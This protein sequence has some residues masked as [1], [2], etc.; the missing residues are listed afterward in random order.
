MAYGRYR[1]STMADLVPNRGVTGG[2]TYGGAQPAPQP[3]AEGP[4]HGY[5]Y[6]TLAPAQAAWDEE[7]RNLAPGQSMP[8]QRPGTEGPVTPRRNTP[9]S[10]YGPGGVTNPGYTAPTLPGVPPGGGGGGDPKLATPAYR[11]HAYSGGALDYYG[12]G[13]I[14]GV[15][16]IKRGTVGVTKGFSE[17]GLNGN[18]DVRGSNT[19]KNINGRFFSN[20]PAKPSSI[21]TLLADPRFRA[22]FPN[23]TQVGFDKIDYGDGKPVDV[24]V[25]ANPDTDTAENWAWQPESEAVAAGAGKGYADFRATWDAP[26]TSAP[27]ENHA[28]NDVAYER[29]AQRPRYRGPTMADLV[30]REK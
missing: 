10:G 26:A 21:P 23:A 9:S 18:R 11:T 15:D 13:D 25:N 8:R 7:Y 2:A 16:D 14:D 3:P 6:G 30:E 17:D 20:L 24:L 4:P 12:I 22:Q 5:D 29:L 19:I 1:P 28:M 27:P